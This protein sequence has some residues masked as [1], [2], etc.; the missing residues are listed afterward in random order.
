[1]ILIYN[2]LTL[3][4]IEIDISQADRDGRGPI[5]FIKSIANILPYKNK[6]CLFIPSKSI[7]PINSKNKS[8]YFYKSYPYFP[9]S[10][11]NEW[12]ISNRSNN[13]ILGPNFIPSKWNYFPNKRLWKEREIRKI[14]INIKGIVVHSK[15][16]RNHLATRSNTIDLSK[17]FIIVRAC[18]NAK[19]KYIRPFKNRKID[20]LF[21]EKYPDSNRMNQASQLLSYFN[22]TNLSIEKLKYGRYSR[23]HMMKLSNQVKFIIYIFRFFFF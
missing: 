22:N 7:R 10:I 1:M 20:I 12:I 13:L 3:K 19:Q 23:I 6:G 18:T 17:K 11:Y 9:E 2:Y 4:I 5:Q 15:R 14:L 21:F 8:N 16:V